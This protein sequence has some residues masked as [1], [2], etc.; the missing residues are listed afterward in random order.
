MKQAQYFAW[1]EIALTRGQSPLLESVVRRYRPVWSRT[2]IGAATLYF[3]EPG[4]EV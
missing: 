1:I 4:R 3:Y 2:S